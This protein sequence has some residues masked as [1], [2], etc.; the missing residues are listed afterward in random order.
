MDIRNCMTGLCKNCPEERTC[1]GMQKSKPKYH[2]VKTIV[3]GIVFDSKKE[4]NRYKELLLLQKAG[5]ITDLKRQVRYTLVPSFNLNKKRYRE[6]SYIADF[7]YKENGKDIVEDTKGFRTDIYKIKK[8]L[9]A[10]IY[11]IEIREI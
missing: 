8:K 10:Y 9:M 6:T 4:A 1:V 5:I 3:N 2:N 7:V 11:Q